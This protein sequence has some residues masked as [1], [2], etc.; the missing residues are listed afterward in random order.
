[1]Q[2]DVF[3]RFLLA[4]DTAQTHAILFA[5]II[6]SHPNLRRGEDWL[7]SWLPVVSLFSLSF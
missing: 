3:T 6:S 5:G 7:Q 4:I 2:A 1:M